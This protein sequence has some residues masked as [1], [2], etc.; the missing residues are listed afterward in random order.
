MKVEFK[1][2][3]SRDLK[4]IKDKELLRE[5]QEVIEV[6]EST[7]CFTEIPNLGKLRVKGHYYR[8]KLGDYRFGLIMDGNTVTF[9][10]FLHRSEIYR[11]FP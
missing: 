4:R 3:F 9:I 5:I 1:A 8:V 6:I 7:Q 2:S 11:Y 10:R